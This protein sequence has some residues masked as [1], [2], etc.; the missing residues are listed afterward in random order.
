MKVL[1]MLVMLVAMA[2]SFS[3]SKDK[4]ANNGAAPSEETSTNPNEAPSEKTS[5][6]PNEAPTET[7]PTKD[8]IDPFVTLGI[9]SGYLNGQLVPVSDF[10]TEQG[11][12]IKNGVVFK[13]D[14]Q[15]LPVSEFLLAQGYFIND[16]IVYKSEA[17]YLS[18]LEKIIPGL[19][20]AIGKEDEPGFYDWWDAKKACSKKIPE[21]TWVLPNQYELN[22][23]YENRVFIG[24][25]NITH[26]D[27]PWYWSSTIVYYS[28]SEAYA[29]KF[30]K[31]SYF[32]GPLEY[33]GIRVRCIRRF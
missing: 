2:G 30:D 27:Y 11:Y 22:E 31:G 16:G 14:E 33:E 20:F 7:L 25:L 19:K 5:T 3:C 9:K 6:N 12:T 4:V 28:G 1:L 15:I 10:F 18:T 23:I 24:G 13:E 29:V 21:G 32:F 26:G 17:D 8:K